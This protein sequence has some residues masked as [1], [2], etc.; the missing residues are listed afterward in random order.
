MVSYPETSNDPFTLSLPQE[1]VPCKLNDRNLGGGSYFWICGWNSMMCHA[2]FKWLR[3]D[4]TF[5]WYYSFS[6]WL[7]RD[8]ILWCDYSNETSSAVLSHGSIYWVCN[9]KVEIWWWNPIVWPFKWNLF[10]SSF[11]WHHLLDIKLQNRIRNF[12][13]ILTLANPG[14][15]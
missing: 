6:M 5:T 9:N 7:Y 2:P 12:C 8:E 4:R 15:S 1:P 13:W 11:A 3:F 14:R 10:S